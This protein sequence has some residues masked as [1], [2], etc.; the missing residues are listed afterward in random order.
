MATLASSPHD[1]P[2]NL[3]H[4]QG[5]LKYGVRTDIP[6]MTEKQYNQMRAV[7]GPDPRA[8]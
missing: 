4:T 1:S 3:R 5:D 8:T 7:L 2:N 6:G